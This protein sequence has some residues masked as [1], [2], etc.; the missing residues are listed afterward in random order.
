ATPTA[1]GTGS[2]VQI[3]T[4]QHTTTGGPLSATPTAAGTGSGPQTAQAGPPVTPVQ[5]PPAGQGT[6][7]RPAPSGPVSQN[8][9]PVNPPRGTRTIPGTDTQVNV[10][11][12]PGGD[13]LMHVLGQV[14]SRVE[15]I[16]MNSEAGEHDDWGYAERN[17]RGGGDIS[18]HASGTAVDVNATRHPL[19]AR[20]TFTPAQVQEIHTI[21]GEVDDV[22]RWGGDYT[23]RRDEMHFEIVGTPEE[24]ARVAERLRAGQ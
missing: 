4:P 24:V 10:A 16:D 17:V 9:W 22:V 14:H 19:G 7:A 21:L 5:T 12:G 13:V 6:G 11:D 1:A 8:G 23:G 15:N 20:E 3:T 18:N 2:G